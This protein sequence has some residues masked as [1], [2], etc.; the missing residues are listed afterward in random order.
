MKAGAAERDITPPDGSRIIYTST[1]THSGPDTSWLFGGSPAD[2]EIKDIEAAI[3][4]SILEAVANMEDAVLEA[5]NLD[6][7]LSHN[8]RVRDANGKTIMQFVHEPGVTDG[9]ADHEM[10]LLYFR[11][12]SDSSTIAVLYNYAAHALTVGAKNMLY[13]ADFPGEVRRLLEPE[14]G[15]QIVF[16]NGAA[17]DIHPRISM[18]NDFS[19]LK[20]T[21]RQFADAIREILKNTSPVEADTLVLVRDEIIFTNRVDVALKVKVDIA[22]LTCG[23]I[24]AGFVPGEFFNEFQSNF[25]RQVKNVKPDSTVML[26]GYCGDWVGYVPTEHEYE[27]GGYGVQLRTTDPAQYSRTALPKGAGEQIIARLAEMALAAPGMPAG[28]AE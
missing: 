10:I 24:I 3:A 16:L 27:Y 5:G 4:D 21:G 12:K 23:N 17:G 15:G 22:V 9:P 14:L 1:H 28:A 11:R 19:A 13:T 7:A 20:T 25:K 6:V 2:R 8:R 26:V 18:Q